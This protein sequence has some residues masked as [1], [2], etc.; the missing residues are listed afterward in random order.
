MARTAFG[1]SLRARTP[2]SHQVLKKY[3]RLFLTLALALHSGLVISCLSVRFV[4]KSELT[5]FKD[6]LAICLLPP[7]NVDVGLC[8]QHSLQAFLYPLNLKLS[9]CEVNS[10]MC[11]NAL[12]N[13]SLFSLLDWTNWMDW[14]DWA[15]IITFCNNGFQPLKAKKI[16]Q[17]H[18][19]HDT[20]NFRKYPSLFQPHGNQLSRIT[21]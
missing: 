20:F 2:E 5:F 17:F 1:S 10:W 6:F 15:V 13:K 11:R 7:S 21:I 8:T 12:Q 4:S 19:F 18:V 16:P 14:M 3:V 9:F